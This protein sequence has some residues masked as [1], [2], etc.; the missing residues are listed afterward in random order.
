M[1]VARQIHE[2]I[3]EKIA[4]PPGLRNRPVEVIFLLLDQNEERKLKPEDSTIDENGWPIGFFEATFGSAPD[5]P[6]RE[7]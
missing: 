3:P 5:I 4:I 6:E 7:S 1:K 2:R